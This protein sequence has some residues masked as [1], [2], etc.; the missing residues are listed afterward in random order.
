MD[1]PTALRETPMNAEKDLSPDPKVTLDVDELRRMDAY[2]PT[3]TGRTFSSG[4]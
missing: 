1:S 3:P 2:W 4:I